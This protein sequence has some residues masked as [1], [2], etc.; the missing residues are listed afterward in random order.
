MNAPWF[1]LGPGEMP[2]LTVDS[3]DLPDERGD[4][5]QS[6]VAA[7]AGTA[8]SPEVQA[9]VAARERCVTELLTAEWERGG[10]DERYGLRR[11][12]SIGSTARDLYAWLPADHD[13]MVETEAPQEWIDRDAVRQM[14]ERLAAQ[15]AVA[16]EFHAS[17]EE[18]RRLRAIFLSSLK[19]RGQASLVGRLNAVWDC[20][21]G[22]VQEDILVDVTFGNVRRTADYALWMQAYLARLPAEW[23]A[24]QT[25]EIRLAKKMF[26]ALGEVYGSQETGL[27]PITIEQW[28]I[29]NV[30]RQPSGLPVG[31]FDAV[32]RH[33]AKEALPF[34][35]YRQRWPVWRPGLSDDE[36]ACCA[37]SPAINLLDLLANGDP[38]LAEAK[39]QRIVTL[40][41]AYMQRREARQAWTIEALTTG[42]HDG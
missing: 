14:L 21:N 8:F 29:Q 42:Q 25:A 35:Q 4:F 30:R 19:V 39:W 10:F 36:V 12:R 13:L 32:L 11:L 2:E 17:P 6:Y 1:V 41:R 7:L 18:G 26:K 40:A 16:P 34:A 38:V 27:R 15:L 33:V 24:R 20:A 31:T 5:G 23:R 9:Q 22:E 28:V 37:I 3:H